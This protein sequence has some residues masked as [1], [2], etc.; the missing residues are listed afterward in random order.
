[1]QYGAKWAAM[2]ALVGG[3]LVGSV[4]SNTAK[5]PLLTAQDESASTSIW[6]LNTKP[7][8]SVAVYYSDGTFESF[9]HD[10]KIKAGGKYKLKHMKIKGHEAIRIDANGYIPHSKTN[11]KTSSIFINNKRHDGRWNFVTVGRMQGPDLRMQ[12][13]IRG[14]SK[15]DLG[16]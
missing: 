10:K 2:V 4:Y 8:L 6:M 14:L 1:M 3:T 15:L 12:L 9:S 5:Q 16:K 7:T 11:F 13:K